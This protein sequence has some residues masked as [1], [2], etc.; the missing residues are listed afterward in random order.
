MLYFAPRFTGKIINIHRKKYGSQIIH[1]RRCRRFPRLRRHCQRRRTPSPRPPSL[2]PPPQPA[3]KNTSTNAPTARPTRTTH[4]SRQPP[5]ASPPVVP[6]LPTACASWPTAT[7]A[8]ATAPKPSIKCWRC[9][10]PPTASPRNRP[11]CYPPSPNS[12][13]MPANSAPK[14]ARHTPTTTPN[15]RPA[16]KPATTAP[17]NA[18]KSLPDCSIR[19]K[20]PPS[21]GLFPN[22]NRDDHT[23][24]HHPA[25][26]PRP[27]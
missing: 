8:S 21:G 18:A 27:D 12:A 5:P 23:R 16:S 4:S 15:A 25:H 13:L 6:A 22:E 10:T 9:A 14:P 7:R 19:K 20:S 17:N 1:Q 11:H 2:S 3:P 26:R 24:P